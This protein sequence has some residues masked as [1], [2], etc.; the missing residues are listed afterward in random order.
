M[1]RFTL[2]LDRISRSGFATLYWYEFCCEE[3]QKWTQCVEILKPITFFSSCHYENLALNLKFDQFSVTACSFFRIC[4]SLLKCL[5]LFQLTSDWIV[6]FGFAE[7]TGFLI[8]DLS[9]P[10]ICHR[11]LKKSISFNTS[12]IYLGIGCN[13]TGE[14]NCQRNHY[15]KMYGVT[16][17]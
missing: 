4:V 13:R 9:V 12:S 10:F 5:F 6:A 3:E 16:C 11:L 7:N 2:L 14:Q 17:L 8:K 1:Q 15:V